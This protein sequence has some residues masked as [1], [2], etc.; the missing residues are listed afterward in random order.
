MPDD[1]SDTQTAVLCD[2]GEYDIN[3]AS[4]EQK[5]DLEYLISGGYVERTEGQPG[6]PFKPTAKGAAF[7]SE[8]GAGLNEA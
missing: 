2:I 1:L 5:R 4:D 8:R 7:L 3:K 6:A